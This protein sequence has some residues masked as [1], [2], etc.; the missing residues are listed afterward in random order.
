MSI[1]TFYVLMFP[2]LAEM[3]HQMT[4][5]VLPRSFRTQ[6]KSTGEEDLKEFNFI[7]VENLH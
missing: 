6:S 5:S 1:L 3:V 2:F 7:L 4:Q